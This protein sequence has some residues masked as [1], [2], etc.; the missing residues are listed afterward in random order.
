MWFLGRDSDRAGIGV[1]GAHG[2]AANGM[3][4]GCRQRNRV[5]TER[6]RLDEI[7]RLCAVLP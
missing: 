6:Q 2:D 4:G 5:G 1:T 7:G 3:H